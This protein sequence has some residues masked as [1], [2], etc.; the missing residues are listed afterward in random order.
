MT[1]NYFRNF[2]EIDYIFGNEL[3][4]SKFEN[5][6]IYSDVVDQVKNV[7]TAYEDYN[8]YPGERPDQVSFNLYGTTEH[9]WTFYL[10]NDKLREQ[11]WPLSNKALEDWATKNYNEIIVNTQTTLT[12]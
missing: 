12:D 6:S 8:I 9:Y 4:A 10:M 5:I 1:T 7:V 11:G 3:N 2:P